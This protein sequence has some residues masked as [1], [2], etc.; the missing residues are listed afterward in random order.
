MTNSDNI[1]TEGL[2]GKA[3][4]STTDLDVKSFAGRE[5]KIAAVFSA[6]IC[7]DLLK[8]IADGENILQEKTGYVFRVRREGDRITDLEMLG[9]R[10]FG[11]IIVKHGKTELYIITDMHGG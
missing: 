2:N 5:H 7:D 6:P 9:K 10:L 1:V 4:R 8:G 3:Y 11:R